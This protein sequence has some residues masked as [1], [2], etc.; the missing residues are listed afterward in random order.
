MCC[1]QGQGSCHTQ[2]SFDVP[3]AN[4]GVRRP[5]KSGRAG[6]VIQGVKK[7]TFRSPGG[8]LLDDEGPSCS[9]DANVAI[10]SLPWRAEV[11]SILHH[12]GRSAFLDSHR[13][14]LHC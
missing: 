11:L 1:T 2:P 7:H 5:T 4:R 12:K 9:S 6:H 14:I 8:C 10:D 3:S 13:L